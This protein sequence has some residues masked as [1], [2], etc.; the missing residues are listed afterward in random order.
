[1][2]FS[3]YIKFYFGD[4]EHSTIV[5]AKDRTEALNDI[6]QRMQ[7]SSGMRKLISEATRMEIVSNER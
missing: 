7:T 3:Y 6:V 5:M 1:M 4:H 2:L